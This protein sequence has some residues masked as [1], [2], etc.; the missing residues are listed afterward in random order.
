MW[1]QGGRATG[2]LESNWEVGFPG[3]ATGLESRATP[4]DP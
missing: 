3:D 2:N 1:G 4:G